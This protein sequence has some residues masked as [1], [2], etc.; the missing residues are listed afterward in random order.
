[1]D[2]AIQLKVN[3]R[4]RVDTLR[5]VSLLAV[6]ASS[7]RIATSVHTRTFDGELVLLDLEGGDYFALDEIGAKFWA[8]IEAGKTLDALAEEIASEYDVTLAQAATDLATLRDELLARGLL[9][10]E[11]EGT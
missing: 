7:L 4:G 5:V 1:M 9:V 3:A 6:T 11:K 8:G 2:C 10:K